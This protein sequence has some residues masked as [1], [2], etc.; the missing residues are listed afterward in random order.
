MQRDAL[1]PLIA[2]MATLPSKLSKVIYSTGAEVMILFWFTLAACSA[3]S[4]LDF[5]PVFGT[6]INSH[7][8]TGEMYCDE[9]ATDTGK[10]IPLKWRCD[11]EFDCVDKSDEP[12]DC[13]IRDCKQG[14]F[15]CELTHL[16]I[17]TSYRC[18]REFDCGRTNTGQF[19]PSD[20]FNE[21]CTE[22]FE[23]CPPGTHRCAYHPTCIPYE[24]FCDHQADCPDSSDEHDECHKPMFADKQNQTCQYGAISV[25]GEGTV[26]FCPPGKVHSDATGCVDE[27]EC[28]REMDGF[29]P[30]CQQHCKNL[31]TEKAGDK[32]YECSCDPGYKLIDNKWCQG[33]NVPENE[34]ATGFFVT[35]SEIV[36]RTFY[37]KTSENSQVIDRIVDRTGIIGM[38][39]AIDHRSRRLC[40]I[41]SVFNPTSKDRNQDL[42]CVKIEADGKFGDKVLFQPQFDLSGVSAIQYDWVG[43]N[44][45]FLDFIY[46]RIFMC[47]D[48][49]MQKC[50]T[51][52]KE[53]I[54]KP[55]AMY[56]DPS[57]G[58]IFYAEKSNKR[59]GVWRLNMDGTDPVYMTP[60]GVLEPK[61]LA[62]DPGS[63]TI[64][65]VDT[66]LQYLMA[67]DYFNR[68]QKRVIFSSRL[69][70][71]SSIAFID[72]SIYAIDVS[73][74]L[75][76][77][78]ALGDASQ[79][80]KSHD[81]STDMLKTEALLVFH[82]KQQPD[83][84]HPCQEGNG[85]CQHF[86]IP[87][88][89]HVIDNVT[90]QLTS[91]AKAICRCAMGYILNSDNKCSKNEDKKIPLL[92]YGSTR[93]GTLAA[94]RMDDIASTGTQNST[95]HNLPTGIIPVVNLR[96]LTAIGLDISKEELYY[97]DSKNYTIFKRNVY[98]GEPKTIINEG[99]QNV[100]GL[101]IDWTSRTIYWTDQGLLQVMAARLDNPSIR[102]TIAKDDMTNP[103]AIVVYPEKGFIFWSDWSE[104]YDYDSEQGKIERSALDGSYRL[105]IVS[106]NVHWPNGMALDTMNDWLYWC[107]AYE[108]RIERVRFNGTGR[109]VI[110]QGTVLNHP[111]GIAIHKDILFWSEH[112]Q[113]VIKRATIAEDG[114]M[115]S[116]IV[117]IFN[118]SAP[119]FELHVYSSELQTATTPCSQDNGGCEHFCVFTNC[120]DLLGCKP[121]ECSCADGY[122]V[123]ENDKRKC[124]L[125]ENHVS[126]SVC[127]SNT[128]FVCKRNKKCIEKDHVCDGDD[129]CGDASD[130]DSGP[131]GVCENFKCSHEQF[132]CKSSNQCIDKNWVCDREAD[133]RSGEDE[134]N[135]EV[136]TVCPKDKFQCEI[137][138]RC[139]PNVFRC[140]GLV[141]CGREDSSDEVGCERKE[142]D[143]KYFQCVNGKC[144]TM[145]M[146]CDG[147]IDC[148]DGSD[149][150]KCHDGC[151]HRE[152]K[153][154]ENGPCLNNYFKCDGIPDCPDGSDEA[155]EHCP[156]AT[157]KWHED[158]KYINEFRCKTGDQC[159]RKA[160]QCD[161][162]EDCL[163]GS[164]EHNCPNITCPHDKF[165]CVDHSR[166]IPTSFVCDG[167]Q[168][169]EDN[170][171]ETLCMDNKPEFANIRMLLSGRCQTPWLTCPKTG[172][173]FLQCLSP[174]KVC[175]GTPDCDHGEDE[176]PSCEEKMCR[177]ESCA[178]LCY[179]RPGGFACGCREGYALHPD[180]RNCVKDDPCAFGTCSQLCEKQGARRYCYC[181]D[182]FTMTADKFTCK[183][184][185]L[186]QPYLIF[187]NR[188]EI[189]MN[190]LRKSG[191]NA[192]GRGYYTVSVPS[193][194][195]L[196][197]T[198]ALDYYYEGP[199]ELTLFW[200]D[201]A[202]DKIYK[203]KLRH[204]VITDV[205]PVVSFG[206]WTAE[207]IAVDWMGMN[208]YWVDSLLDMIQV[209]NFNGT[210]STT[211]LS[212]NMHSLRA[213]ALD[214][215]KGFMFW[216]DWEEGNARI[217]R[218]TMAGNDRKI[219][220][221]VS[222]LVNS[223]WPN[224]LTCDFIAERI[225]WIDAKSDSIYSAT[226]DGKDLRLVLRDIVHL[227]HP[228][229]I[230][231]FENHVYWTDWRVTAIYRA[232]KWN[233]T[234]I[235]LIESSPSQP[236]D[237]KVVHKTRQP[238]S[239]KNPCANNG[240]CSHL[241]LIESQTERRCACPHM[242]TLEAAEKPTQCLHVNQTLITASTEAIYAIDMDYPH[243]SVFPV[244][245]GK[246]EDK[247]T[248][249]AADPVN[250][251]LFWVD[252]FTSSIKKMHIES[253][254]H[255]D[256]FAVR[257][258]VVNCYGM[259]VDG[260]LG[261]V[262]YTGWVNTS[263]D[264]RAWIGVANASG[265]YRQTIIDARTQKDL[266][267]PNDLV[268]D[269]SRGEMYWLD[270]GYHPPALFKS[271]MDGRKMTRIIVDS[272]DG[273]A[274]ENAFSLT[275]SKK[276]LMWTQPQLK[277][278]RVLELSAKPKLYTVDYA[279][280]AD[281]RPTLVV[282]DDNG[283]EIIF[284]D[285]RSGN[286]TA[287]MLSQNLVAGGKA[288]KLRSSQRVL[289]HNNPDL[290]SMKIF[291]RE[292]I[293]ESGEDK[294]CAKLK[295]DH[296]CIRSGQ[297][298]KC[299]CSEGYNRVNGICTPPKKMLVYT[300]TSSSVF[301]VS[302]DQNTE[303]IPF[304]MV[305][306]SQLLSLS[307]KWIATD[308]N[309]NRIF[310]IDAKNNDLWMIEN[311][312]H[313]AKKV[314]SGGSARLTGLAVD[315]V[316]GYLYI[317][318]Q[319]PGRLPTSAISLVSPD[320]EDLESKIAILPNDTAYHIFVDSKHDAGYLFW[321]STQGV[322]RSRLD[323]SDQKLIYTSAKLSLMNLDNDSK[324]IL[325]FFEGTNELISVNYDGEEK[326]T[327]AESSVKYQ[328]MTVI[329][330][331]VYYFLN[332]KLYSSKIKTDGTLSVD[333]KV[334]QNAS[335]VVKHF[336][337]LNGELKGK[338]INPCSKNNGGC[339]QICFYMGKKEGARCGCSFS[340]LKN[341]KK[342]CEQY[343]SF[344]AYSRGPSIHFA[345]IVP[346]DTPKSISFDAYEETATVENGLKPIFSQDIVRNAVGLTADVERYQLIFSDVET[347]RIVAVKYDSS[348]H[349]IVAK[350]V[351]IVEGIAF[352]PSNRD[353]YF[354]SGRNIMRVSVYST[355]I[356]Q[357]PQQAKTLLRLGE[358]DRP[359]GIAV[360]PC[361]M[362][363]Y[364][365]NWRDDFPSIERVFFSGYKRERI[366]VTDIRTP[367][368]ITIDFLAGKLYW[369]D[370]KLDKIERTD[371]DGTNREI[372]VAAKSGNR[373]FGQPQHPFG[374]SVHGDYLYYTDWA[375]RAV[376][377]VNKLSGIGQTALSANF[378]EQPLGI[379]VVSE[380]AAK[381]G[382]DA[383]SRNDLEC[384]D[385]CR[386]TAS[387]KPHCACNGDRTLNPDGKT[388]SGEA[389]AE[390]G[391]DEFTCTS[392]GRCIPYDETCDGVEECPNG[393]DEA[394][395]FCAYR[396][397]REGY[398]P[399]GNGRCIHNSKRCDKLNDC[400]GYE[401]EVNC[402]C[403][404]DEFR[405]KNGQCIDLKYRCDRNQHCQDA[406]DE[407]G[408]SKIDCTSE[409]SN[410]VNCGR[411]TQCIDV[412]WFCDGN[413]DCWD[414]WDEADCPQYITKTRQSVY[415]PMKVLNCSAMHH[416]CES[417]GTCLP[418]SW[419]C[420]GHPD[421]ATG[422]DEKNCEHT[423]DK[424]FE[425]VCQKDKKC[426]DA[427]KRCNGKPDCEDG[428]DEME[429]EEKCDQ[430]KF[431]RCSNN[432]CIPKGWRCDGTDDCMDS[433]RGVSSDEEGCDPSKPLIHTQ[434]KPW[435]F[436][437]NSST[438]S[439]LICIPRRHFCDGEKDC[440]DGSDEP[441]ICAHNTCL[442]SEFRCSSGQCVHLNWTCNGIPDCSDQ[443]DEADV[444]CRSIRPHDKCPVNQF[445]CDNGV[446]LV[447]ETLL[448]DKKNDCG[449][450][451][452]EKLCSI[453]EC[454]RDM[455]CAEICED[456]KIGYTCSCSPGKRL[457]E[458]L[459]SCEEENACYGHNCT[460][461][462]DPI[463]PTYRC[464]C[465]PGYELGPDLRTCR[466]ADKLTPEI[467][468]VNR[469][470]IRRFTIDGRSKGMI[471]ANMSNGVA[472]DYDYASQTAFWTDITETISM[473]GSTSLHGAKNH[474]RVLTGI[475][476]SSPDGIA[477]DWIGKNVYWCDK[478]ADSI[479]VADMSGLY[480]KTL[481]KGNPL[482]DPRA[483]VVDPQAKVLFWSDW[484]DMPHIGKMNM[485]GQ[486]QALL[487]TT[488]LKWP[489]ALAVDTIQARLYWGDAHLDYIASCDY[490]GNNRRLVIYKSVKHIFGLS[491]FEDYIYWT[492]WTKK[493][494]ERAHKL[495]GKHRKTI[496]E[497]DVYRPMGIKIVHPLLQLSHKGSHVH[498]PCNTPGRCDNMC[499]PSEEEENFA[500]LCS[501][502][503]KL[504]NGKCVSDCNPTD[505]VCH[506]TYKCIPFY[507]KCDG[508]NDCGS[509]ED[510]PDDCPAF[511]CE[512]GEM[513][514][515]QKAGN[516]TSV[517]VTY[518]KIC[519]GTKD[520]PLN[521]DEDK[522]LCS[523]YT[524]LEGQYK[525][526]S[527]NK[528]ISGTQICDKNNDCDDGS[529]EM[530]CASKIC[531]STTFPCG[532]GASR[533]CL[534]MGH[535]CDGEQDCE[536]GSD[537]TKELCESRQ[538]PV[539]N[540]RCTTGKCIPFSWKCDGQK[541]CSD[542][543]DEDGCPVKGVCL[544]KQFSCKS[545]G[546]CI[547]LSYICDGDDDCHDASD[548][549][550]CGSEDLTPAQ[551]CSTPDMLVC[552]DGLS[553]FTSSQKCDGQYNCID[554]SDETNCHVCS[555][556]SFTCG[557]PSSKCIDMKNVCDGTIDCADE[558]DEIYCSCSGNDRIGDNSNSFRCYDST[559]SATSSSYC[560]N[561]DHVCDGIQH[562]PNGHDESDAVC[563][564]HQCPE[565][566]LK[567]KNGR[568]YP[569][570]GYCDG[571]PDCQDESDEDTHMCERH[572]G[573]DSFKCANGRCIHKA[574]KCLMNGIGG[575]GDGSDCHDGNHYSPQADFHCETFGKCSQ[576]C[577]LHSPDKGS[578]GYKCYCDDGYIRNGTSCKSNDP[579][580]AEAVM[581]DGRLIRMLKPKKTGKGVE[582]TTMI[583]SQIIVD[584]DFY[585]DD[586]ENVTYV[587]VDHS[588][589][590]YLK[591]GSLDEMLKKNERVKRETQSHTETLFPHARTN[592][593][594]DHVNKNVYST[595]EI[596]EGKLLI[597]R[598]PLRDLSRRD[599]IHNENGLAITSLAVDPES[600]K[601][602]WA[603]TRPLAA[604]VCIPTNA[605]GHKAYLVR[606]A[607][608][609]PTS[610]VI[611]V[612]N[613]R[614][615]WA[616]VIKG[617]IES[618]LMNGKD[619]VV[620]KK[621]GYQNGILHDRPF[622]IDVFEDNLYVIGKPNGTVW[623]IHK[624]GSKEETTV[625]K[626]QVLSSAG[627]LKMVH[628][629]KRYVRPDFD[630]YPCA[631]YPCN[632]EACITLNGSAYECICPQRFQ[633][634]YNG[635]CIRS[636][637]ETSRC[638]YGSQCF[639]GGKCQANTCS[640]PAGFTGVKC[641]KTPCTDYCVGNQNGQN[642]TC[643]LEVTDSEIIPKCDCSLEFAGRRCERYKCA[644]MCGAHGVCHIDHMTGFPKCKCDIGW[645]GKDCEEKL[646]VC[647]SFCFNG[648]R[649]MQ[650]VSGVPYCE[651]PD[652][653]RGRR[654]ENCVTVNTADEIV[655]LNGGRCKSRDR[656][657]CPLGYSGSN[658]SK[659][660]CEGYCM[661]G[662][663]CIR[664]IPRIALTQENHRI[665]CEC[666]PGYSGLQCE[667]DAC[668]KNYC[669]NGGIC[670]HHKNGT[671]T[672]DCPSKFQGKQCEKKRPCQDY[673]LN[674]SECF[675]KSNLEWGCLCHE[676]YRGDMCDQF[677]ACGG[678]ENSGLCHLDEIRGPV[679]KCPKGLTGHRCQFISA[680]NCGELDCMN[681][682]FCA[683]LT[684]GRP[685]CNCYV[686]WDGLICSEPSCSGYC[687]DK[688]SSCYMVNGKPHCKCSESG[689]VGERCQ[690]QNSVLRPFEEPNPIH[691]I[692]IAC[693]L[694][695][696]FGTMFLIA[697]VVHR[698]KQNAQFKHARMNEE[699][700]DA[701]MDEFN[702]PAFLAGGEDDATEVTNFTNPMYENVYNDTVTSD[703]GTI[704]KPN[705]Q[706]E[707]RG[708]LKNEEA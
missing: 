395:E 637:F 227:A 594:V 469:R 134:A 620:V 120:K 697:F 121:V 424:E 430:S 421:C 633:V 380:D 339:E 387:G 547:P 507:W 17:P 659:D 29:A 527:S 389:F 220:I 200:S 480:S 78:N 603:E 482:Q 413:N 556:S 268:L 90:N 289:K 114:N 333:T 487:I 93:P 490:M 614:L 570:S 565:G 115:T 632:N 203:G 163:D 343:K 342:T 581:V 374:L 27:N 599:L 541:D 437:C 336:T 447:N 464:V 491:I 137:T 680:M 448:C 110:I 107:D 443:S 22:P 671:V 605:I 13:P 159:V 219:I 67:K 282:T 231:V 323:G 108:K 587:W 340:R 628:P 550:D 663:S 674:E 648:G 130:E 91:T 318:S 584:F 500:C 492:D 563:A 100:E 515:K 441:S 1:K 158:C 32:G 156:N 34:E 215:G 191:K 196:R 182:H 81:L 579:R 310:I 549:E 274:T 168:D 234:S 271:M 639:N 129:D 657:V 262:Y 237:M 116:G 195:Q 523:Q 373:S 690:Y 84:S 399:C 439:E 361:R 640:C 40:W 645:G 33:T 698:V 679:C 520:C 307:P 260:R 701:H 265:S 176:G 552:K 451:S 281:A 142:C 239:V 337:I 155:P 174:E 393:E 253:G 357:Y 604:I 477:V 591:K 178:H 612:P 58:F 406:S 263:T 512:Q 161:G 636:P 139:L 327:M 350:D 208:V 615:Y 476:A 145:A 613:R 287:R 602:C 498:H 699:P 426:I 354:T 597:Y 624:F 693:S 241:C 235:A 272:S 559:K 65:W 71:V 551:L 561:K 412:K 521:D 147:H 300:A 610:M 113:S 355:D 10:C 301:M 530:D 557:N 583:L 334:V 103:R 706:A 63:K 88:Y 243:S 502:G 646:D 118:D 223:G 534:Q 404:K 493:T 499:V 254:N 54:E 43:H 468:V 364:Y 74:K 372:V 392:T 96:R 309:R 536:D 89:D 589:G 305:I 678:C 577:S 669:Q 688:N 368:S 458:D 609:E 554:M 670:K 616:D 292:T 652:G 346:T 494:V 485:D 175:D 229:A 150:I 264:Q 694:M 20:E 294:K 302:I 540:F 436:R 422:S 378:T 255:R 418:M 643:R 642:H 314:I 555:N 194:T 440:D 390:C 655:C 438:I 553:C 11:G 401:D 252:E 77:F 214:P 481:L 429:C 117:T 288:F 371:M 179:N 25:Y 30:I 630:L 332:N 2:F 57:A 275:L 124:H 347:Q 676:N 479:S 247:I 233:G 170:S 660:L 513:A 470:S 629:L 79:Q 665:A 317:G 478:D 432:K 330:Q 324:R 384:E 186:E 452:D 411:T 518:D 9:E 267:Q 123:D 68:F 662:G 245:A 291:D 472:V 26:C 456:Q 641:E 376:V 3:T 335:T 251:D 707:E 365:T 569:Y 661:N 508:Q 216:T 169:C 572:C 278:T 149:E 104:A 544:P 475:S 672:C 261:V 397:C 409:G 586:G 76:E 42:E 38:P 428:S 433:K 106:K 531:P 148:R 218:A 497:F 644:G 18:D 462:C 533:R 160:F 405:C 351:G 621:Y 379:V 529:D 525:C 94:I 588:Y 31:I 319:L 109:Q 370:A 226:Y 486:H 649:C 593:A 99:I 172:S 517:C 125:N 85:A 126:P 51:V 483:I 28:D 467:L 684:N 279:N 105:T 504:E 164:D 328:A 606:Y 417:T 560:V 185:D 206:I 98:D 238:R 631:N 558:S 702:N 45:Y 607:I 356:Q 635:K 495:S 141:D 221:E 19:D 668:S 80:L 24:K 638:R 184:T 425:F 153:C 112:R 505:F 457:L 97:S 568:C 590:S 506:K 537:E 511:H 217:E 366:I 658:C 154:F 423:C 348:E 509:N 407:M 369:S 293:E 102:K 49:T 514:C 177:N 320:I 705:A 510:E 207:G 349:F 61:V 623:K 359:R 381:C 52:R 434:C 202:Y 190:S 391:M 420:D 69:K 277:L 416:T 673:C 446:C 298:R 248:A 187:T 212:G 86:C 315:P 445:Q 329:D 321:L 204:G 708:L 73:E 377:M 15:R 249:I 535:L 171:D 526:P 299:L 284:Y 7:C 198:I 225:Y 667:H 634:Y 375:Y 489:N 383:C 463:G 626:V 582:I 546:R 5:D 696:I 41:K 244:V 210:A 352:D 101:A 199:G 165:A 460:Q 622:A 144:I 543:A 600:S 574:F 471:L 388:C 519:D 146:V 627:K 419:V 192:P 539:H 683:T 257:G 269:L 394:T 44:W 87:S 14:E 562:C 654:C 21:A 59:S 353:V 12:P 664:K 37:N 138:K 362:Y 580:K 402:V 276:R 92:L 232:N 266:R 151:S 496:I 46:R 303:K 566:Y 677:D 360:D 625:K 363:I 72:T 167:Y 180:K 571:V 596:M 258:D 240:G 618:V 431:F 585:S 692:T 367:N 542:G 246:N 687:Y 524:C 313:V 695:A 188:H 396:I 205:E 331:T 338:D 703:A 341:D 201:I 567:C 250:M 311:D 143:P 6:D 611:D 47:D 408:C 442:G 312:L 653:Y 122:Y 666:L 598:A 675:D 316:T 516:S 685:F 285:S 691:Y 23:K 259:D 197:N 283:G 403:K 295:C 280:D 619:R 686:G 39:M 222:K 228:F 157:V 193:L 564:R 306:P 75:L 503:F 4:L 532:T 414:N 140:D 136:G 53:G 385:V 578:I 127:D 528:C 501:K 224:G 608:Y 522:E 62:G 325:V 410:M 386:M 575:C 50:I 211:V 290:I 128:H 242:M 449:D 66:Y 344:I 286:I 651:C 689:Y 576:K 461:I 131:G 345:G 538:C 166:C 415:K 459:R 474:Y 488:S 152:F 60:G 213:L 308:V 162:Q 455:P 453:D 681:D 647:H 382:D 465:E 548:E 64:Y 484:G 617:T 95:H 650:T 270:F 230:S 358:F 656:C 398:F 273:S 236:F 592:I 466:H 427:Q 189:R 322:K 132:L 35:P 70:G 704:I 48:T 8:P 304:R 595:A 135:C 444:L 682:G 400:G 573:K 16:C 256:S 326:H 36:H 55:E 700:A 209:T 56:V 297:E 111:Y 454:M 181:A 119:I 545:D 601:L 473:L 173:R 133:C 183:A 83:V 435:Q 450:W 296:L 82:R